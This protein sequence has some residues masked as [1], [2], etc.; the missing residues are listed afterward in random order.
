MKHKFT[1]TYETDEL[2]APSL[3][4][5]DYINGERLQHLLGWKGSSD[6]GHKPQAS[7]STKKTQLNDIK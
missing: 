6:F 1:I 3:K 2:Q 5:Q 4:R 7:S